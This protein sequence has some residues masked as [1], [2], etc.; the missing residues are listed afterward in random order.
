[1]NNTDG[2]RM[3]LPVLLVLLL[4]RPSPGAE[5]INE[6]KVEA[7]GI[8]F[9]DRDFVLAA[10]Q[11][12]EGDQLDPR[13]ISRDVRSLLATGRFSF[14]DTELQRLDDGY[15]LV[16]RLAVRPRLQG[17]VTIEGA[18]GVSERRV[19]N[20]LELEPGDAVDDAIMNLRSR[21]VL[22]E[23]HKRFYPD[24]QADWSID[25][26]PDSGFAK[27]VYR[28]TEGQRASLRKV[29]FSGNTYQPPGWR[30]RWRLGLQRR[31]VVAE[32]SVPPEQ[33]EAVVRP[34]LWHMFSFLTKRG[35]YNQDDL[36]VDRLALQALYHNRGYLD[37]HIGSPEVDYYRPR[38]LQAVFPVTE[39]P[40][41]RIGGISLSN[42]K[43]FPESDLQSLIRLRPGDIAAMDAIQGAA[44][45]MRDYYWS[46][47]YMR[48]QVR[49]RL[50][51]R[52]EEPVVDVEFVFSEGDVVNIRYIDIRGNTRTKDKVIRRELLVYPGELYDMVRV[53]R[54][55]RILQNLGYFSKV[56]SYP[57][58][59]REPFSDDL[60]YEVE[61]SRTGQF[62][63]GAGYSSV[64][65]V[66]GFAELSQGNFDLLGWPHFIG[67]GQ[68]LR[69]RAQV[70]TAM[71]DYLISFV[72]PWFLDRKLS[73]G[74]DL[75]NTTRSNLSDYYNEERLGAAVTLGKPLR[76][77]FHRANLRYSLEEIT[78]YN[79]SDDAV[80]RIKNEAGARTVSSLK[81][82]FIHDTRDNMFVP[83]SGVRNTLAAR[84]SGGPLG[85]D[86]DMYG[87]EADYSVY[88]P[89][90]FGH[91]F[92][93]RGWAAV[94]QEYGD[95]DDVRLFD[96]LFLGGARTLRGFKYR[97]VSPY[98]EGEPIGGKTAA[99]AAAEYTVPLT[100]QVLRLAFFY[101]LGNVWLDAY[102]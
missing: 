8:R 19:R 66:I 25:T 38:R 74:L 41:Y 9:Q 59:T 73:L 84:V 86:T 77:Y 80:Q 71:Q 57:R 39:G 62:M 81:L 20:W 11:S 70:G 64:D 47:G 40:Q 67:G 89:L 92:N 51:P 102:E 91:V 24:V 7:V 28:V 90:W 31:E 5:L 42:L 14:V 82:T 100:R 35:V 29:S 55:E 2:W 3:L 87:L 49:P 45:T 76:G 43:L 79:I 60:V 10:T 36:E 72:E 4:A 54:S 46:R 97:Y 30:E 32:Q 83:T 6:I 17:P 21:K 88:F 58:E 37:V 101:E 50:Q 15:A 26:D 48:A 68:K 65:E 63:V 52:L 13:R 34:R 95:D 96:R 22:E 56:A 1:M 85:F 27:V 61:E 53:R 94:V 16:Y 33:L 78:I 12:R 99:L 75:Y 98:E 44:E 23:Y 18:E 93:L 69:L